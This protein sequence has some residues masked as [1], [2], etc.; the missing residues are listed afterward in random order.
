[1]SADQD[2]DDYDDSKYEN[3]DFLDNG[4]E[5][6]YELDFSDSKAIKKQHKAKSRRDTRRRLEDYFERK[7][8]K[9]QEDS[10]DFDFDY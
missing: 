1:M 4:L 7:A 6:A 9:E 2:R 8:L 5:D 10:W 3:N